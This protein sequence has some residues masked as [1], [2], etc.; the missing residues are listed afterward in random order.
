MGAPRFIAPTVEFEVSNV[1]KEP[2]VHQCRVF[3]EDIE[4]L[5]MVPILRGYLKL[6]TTLTVAKL[7]AFMESD[8]DEV[9]A[10][11]MCFKHKLHRITAAYDESLGAADD[12]TTDAN[13]DLDFYIDQNMI[14][15]ADTKMC[16]RVGEYFVKHIQKLKEVGV[17]LWFAHSP[18]RD[19]RARH[20][21]DGGAR[22]RAAAHVAASAADA[23]AARLRRRHEGR[24]ATNVA[25]M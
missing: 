7:A 13:A 17:R 3:T 1:S 14:H 2:A 10:R 18:D 8:E 4:Q 24:T 22:G 16:R 20:E 15:V 23:A 5:K 9:R 25:A 11:L 19:G 21:R 6:Y 12:V